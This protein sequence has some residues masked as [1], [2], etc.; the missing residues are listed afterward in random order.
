MEFLLYPRRS[1]RAGVQVQ[2]PDFALLLLGRGLGDEQ[3]E[4]VPE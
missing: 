4:L 2:E 1:H 3:R